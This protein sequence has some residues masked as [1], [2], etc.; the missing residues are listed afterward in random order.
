[1]NVAVVLEHRFLRTPDGRVWTSTT[2]D[3]DFWKRYLEVFDSVFVIARV[4]DV[5][6]SSE[7]WKRVDGERVAVR[8]IPYYHGPW[9]F[10]PRFW[11]VKGGVQE[12]ILPGEAVIL[13]APSTLGNLITPILIKRKQPFA[14]EIVGDP[15]DVFS[16]G[17]VRYPW[18]VRVFLRH[19]FT[20]QLRKQCQKAI[21]CAYVTERALQRRYP[22][23]SQA[24]SASFSN[25]E[26]PSEAYVST[27]R[28]FEQK[29][30]FTLITVGTLDQLYK[31]IDVLINALSIIKGASNFQL[32]IV[33]DGIYRKYLESLCVKKGIRER[34]QF[35]GRLPAG[36]SVRHQLDRAD[37]FV[38]PSRLEGLPRAMIEAMARALP[39]IGTTVGG[40]PELLPPEDRVP[41]NDARALAARIQEALSDPEQMGRM[42][43][44]NLAKAWEYREEVLRE[45][46]QAFYRYVR[47]ATEEWGK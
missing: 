28:T 26:L 14:L 4:L 17:A 37:L 43:A 32:I 3:Y 47:E 33:G 16:P 38:L 45:K 42:S 11:R 9:Q 5:P 21:A 2:F 6:C 25:V 29:D 20:H 15:W 44:R 13:R 31:G 46:R 30:S 24:F 35:A 41:P 1:M 39:C 22:P 10:L 23:G 12:A 19:W 8:P 36:E 7:R 27:A 34:V 40:I 18:P